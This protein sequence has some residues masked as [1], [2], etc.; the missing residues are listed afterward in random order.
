MSDGEGDTAVAYTEIFHLVK[1][2][3]RKEKNKTNDGF[4]RKK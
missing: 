2:I 1:K 3:T 4:W